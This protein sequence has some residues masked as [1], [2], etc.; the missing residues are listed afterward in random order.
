MK[1]A[2]CDNTFSPEDEKALREAFMLGMLFDE[3]SPEEFLQ[4]IKSR[5]EK[6]PEGDAE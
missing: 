3:K 4:I 1:E 6:K 2:A 5:R